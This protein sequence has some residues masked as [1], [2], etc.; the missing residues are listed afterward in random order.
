MACL[1]CYEKTRVVATYV[2]IGYILVNVNNVLC[3]LTTYNCVTL[4][5]ALPEINVY[6][7]TKF[8]IGSLVNR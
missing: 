5:V 1:M 4:T 3:Y 8:I 7:Y 6:L 2:C